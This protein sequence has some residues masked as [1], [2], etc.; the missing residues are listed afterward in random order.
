MSDEDPV[1]GKTSERLFWQDGR[2][3][4]G[5]LIDWARWNPEA[6]AEA[7]RT[8]G[9]P[10]MSADALFS[11]QMMAGARPVTKGGWRATATQLLDGIG[12]RLT[13][14]A[15]PAAASPAGLDA[16]PAFDGADL[17]PP[18]DTP[19]PGKWRRRWPWIRRGLWS[20][21]ALMVLIIGW[22]AV[23]AP[24]SRSL[25]PI[26]P[27]QM[28]ILSAQGTPIARN[29]DI[30]DRPVD[31][32]QLPPHVV[33]AFLATEDRTFYSHIGISARGFTRALWTN[34]TTGR[35]HGGSTI[36]Q[37]LAKFTFLNADQTMTRKARE[38]LIAIWMEVWL[39][40]DEI[41][42]RYLS[43]A[44]FGGRV[45]GLRAASL[46]YFYRQPER[47]TLTQAAMLAGMLR[48]PN[49]YNPLTNLRRA[50]E[51]ERIVLGAMVDAGFLT[52]EQRRGVRMA[53][54]DNRATQGPPSGTYFADWALPQ[55]RA[56]VDPGYEPV[57]VTTTLDDRLQRL[58]RQAVNGAPL[59]RA[60]VALVA[61][62]PNGEVV[63][64]IGGRSYADSAFNRATQARRQPG[65][66][67]KLVVYYAALQAGLTPDSPVDDNPITSGSYRPAN[68]GGRYR[69]QISLRE[70]F[71]QSSNV[72]AVRLYQELGSE[73]IN[74]AARDLGITA[75][76]PDNASVALGSGSMTLLE[77]TAAYAAVAA[78]EAPV[79]PHAI[80]R[81]DQ[82]WFQRMFDGRG[83]IGT[84]AQ[85][86]LLDMLRSVVDSGTGRAA[87]LNVPAFGKTGTSQDSR[88][89]LFVGFA[90]DLV[91]G[92]WVGND[93]NSPLRGVSGGG[94]P[95][96]I[97]R[98]FMAQAVPGAAPQRRAR[99]RPEPEPE[100]DGIFDDLPVN[101]DT[102]AVRID[103]ENGI[104]V[105]GSVGG[106]DVRIGR[107][108][109]DVQPGQ[110]MR[111]RIENIRRRAE[112]L[113]QR[114]GNR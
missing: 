7:R 87:R 69:G 53:T 38:A 46:H 86:H 104:N 99:P 79:E 108:G 15:A 62:R 34:I 90:G 14:G 89:A 45:Y 76:L 13:G 21:A 9:R 22:L 31:V 24:L 98:D 112:E 84:T 93:D 91:V 10:A 52:E 113:E 1:R 58:A 92:V 26:V 111:E 64:M 60:Q 49:R 95:A 8:E 36:T 107:D 28:T 39:S 30:V 75:D 73:R 40:K 29:G 48:A 65:S 37:Q 71:A 42:G 23:T 51:R 80:R 32:T 103:P 4:P 70:A 96:R 105:D 74:Q 85:N 47:L 57:E 27:P 5:M 82:N 63:A 83:P 12:S 55:A 114:V 61:M 17:D 68:A 88:D 109:V 72:V 3:R 78:N 35:T 41:L 25:Q 101:I 6:D 16:P 44:H 50:Q 106:V 102:P 66:T 33:Q 19:P 2:W 67:F 94:L 54:T 11:Q 59:G 81:P 77:L 56:S 100:S 110:Q 43:N 20:F 97:W 18:A